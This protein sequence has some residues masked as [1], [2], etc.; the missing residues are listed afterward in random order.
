[1]TLDYDYVSKYTDK[2]NNYVICFGNRYS[3]F[4]IRHLY[5][6]FKSHLATGYESTILIFRNINIVELLPLVI[7]YIVNKLT[8]ENDS[9]KQRI[10]SC[11]DDNNI[12]ECRFNRMSCDKLIKQNTIAIDTT[13]TLQITCD[14]NIYTLDFLFEPHFKQYS[15]RT[16]FG[17]CTTQE[18]LNSLM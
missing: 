11:N 15:E 1:M 3:I 14:H 4:E 17:G 18:E 2:Y 16:F 9:L 13:K 8:L 5:D 6:F 12:G 10:C 7:E